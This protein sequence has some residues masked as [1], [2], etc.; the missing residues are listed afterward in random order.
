MK[1]GS[2]ESPTEEA[3][4]LLDKWTKNTDFQNISVTISPSARASFHKCRAEM[5]RA[6]TMIEEERANGTLVHN[7][8]QVL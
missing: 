2:Q 3:G 7:N 5:A 1:P 6:L 4:R 8:D